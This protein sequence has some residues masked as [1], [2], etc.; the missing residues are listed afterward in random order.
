M[1]KQV[2]K[3]KQPLGFYVW[4]SANA[5]QR[6]I[7]NAL[8]KHDLTH[9]QFMLLSG[10]QTLEEAEEK[11]TQVRLANFVDANIMMTSKV[12]RTLAEKQLILRKNNPS[13]TRAKI[14]VLTK[15]GNKL[16]NKANKTVAK[17]ERKFFDKLKNKEINRLKSTL[18]QLKK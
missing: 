17:S 4:K 10:I 8:K 2:V 3:F 7:K 11:I 5:W 9:V 13:D 6:H 16:L 14:I 1:E 18:K 12:L 15:N